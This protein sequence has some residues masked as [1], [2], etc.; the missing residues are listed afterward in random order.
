MVTD[1]NYIMVGGN[2]DTA[3][4]EAIGHGKYV[5]FAEI[6]NPGPTTQ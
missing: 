3:L 1:K 6:A 2:V 5:D 4:Q